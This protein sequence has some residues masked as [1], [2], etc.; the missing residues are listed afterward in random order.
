MSDL[1][2]RYRSDNR[3]LWIGALGQIREA[4]SCEVERVAAP[5]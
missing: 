1:P 2:H 5:L 4:A 3:P